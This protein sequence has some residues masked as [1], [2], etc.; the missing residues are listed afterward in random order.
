MSVN[1][2]YMWYFTTNILIYGR[3]KRGQAY[4][5]W[6]VLIPLILYGVVTV[7]KYSPGQRVL[8]GDYVNPRRY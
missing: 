8:V 4:G 7:D 2:D 1:K 3:K 5:F 6:G